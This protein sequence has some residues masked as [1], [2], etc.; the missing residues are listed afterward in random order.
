MSAHPTP[1][2]EPPVSVRDLVKVFGTGPG[3]IRAVDGVALRIE[4]GEIVGLLGPNGAGKTTTVRILA[5]LARRTSGQ[6]AVF[7][8]DPE[9]EPDAVRRLL[10]YVSQETAVDKTLTG[11]E[12]LELQAGLFHLPH[13]TARARIDEVLALVELADRAG[14]AARGYSGGMR[15]RLDL[16]AGLLHRPGLLLLDEPTLGLDIQTRRRIW[17]FVLTLKGAG[18]AILLTTHYLEEADRL[19]D[20]VAI[21][22]HGKIQVEGPPAALKAALGAGIVSIR[23]AAANGAGASAGAE[24]ARDAEIEAALRGLAF[25]SSVKSVPDRGAEVAVKPGASGDE[26][27]AGILRLLESRGAPVARVAYAP[28]TLDDVFLWHTGSSLRE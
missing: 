10:G 5:T 25:V 12:N 9:R 20:R 14:D 11:R 22:D 1:A 19:C 21:I 17:D 26:A 18:T 6:V 28:P 27:V 16:A 13:A 23:L 3:A 15:K 2:P 24:P 4:R 8:H 7:G